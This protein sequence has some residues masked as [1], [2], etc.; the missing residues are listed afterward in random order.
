MKCRVRAIIKSGDQ[1]LLV[2]HNNPEA[3]KNDVWALP[4]GGVDDGET[5]I[6]A[7]ERE[8]VEET[9]IMPTIGRLMFVHQFMHDG[10]YQGPEF[11]FEV[12]NAS[13]Y[14]TI[15]VAATSH[16]SHE[17]AAI[18]FY[19]PANRNTLPGFLKDPTILDKPNT[20]LI[21]RGEGE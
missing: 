9:G 21:I 5:I 4:G 18:G 3:I 7:L 16:G 10:V 12:T 2:Q 11:F 17:L 19:D 13:D 15:D 1:L 8:M 20:Q 14:Q 6:A